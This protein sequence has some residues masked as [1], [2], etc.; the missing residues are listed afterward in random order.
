LGDGKLAHLIALT[1]QPT[2]CKLLVA[3]KH[4]RKTKLLQQQGISAITDHSSLPDRY[5][6][7][8][9][10]ASGSS[11]AFH[12]A[13]RKVRPRGSV[14]LKS[15]YAE[16]FAFNPAPVVVDE[17]TVI[18]SR[19]GRFIRAIEFLEHHPVD[20][21]YLI[22]KRFPLSDGL[23]AFSAAQQSDVMKVVIDCLN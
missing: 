13:L 19:C 14:I 4:A 5:F 1:L 18:G 2:G 21:S 10:E 15:T 16:G 17:I 23:A 12:E 3:G 8:V 22:S 6:D 20:L 11:S 7:I 9:I